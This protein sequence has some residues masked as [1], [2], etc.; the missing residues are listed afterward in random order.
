MI[1]KLHDRGKRLAICVAGGFLLLLL[2][3]QAAPSSSLASPTF[4]EPYDLARGYAYARH[5]DL[6][7]QQEHPVL[8]DGLGGLMLLLMPELTPPE[9]IPGWDDAHLFRFSQALLW[10]L[11]H[12]VDKMVFLARFPVI[13]LALILGA[14]VYRWAAD[15]Y[16]VPGGLLALALYALNPNI[17]A[18]ARILS[19][20]LGAACLAT[21]TLYL[22][23]RWAQ[24][25]TA[26]RVIPAALVLG[27][28][29]AAKTTNMLLI[30][31]IGVLT[32]IRS[33][34][35]RWRWS[36]AVI[37]WGAMASGALFVLWALYRFELGPA[38]NLIGDIPVPAAS[39][40]EAIA[41]VRH[42]MRLG[43][44]AFLWGRHTIWGWWYYFPFAFLVKTP[45]PLLILLVLAVWLHIRR[46]VAQPFPAGCSRPLRSA[47][48]LSAEYALWIF[49]PFYFVLSAFST[50]NL[51]YR[52]ILSTVPLM[53]IYAARVVTWPGM[54]PTL[55]ARNQARRYS[56]SHRGGYGVE[57]RWARRGLWILLTWLVVTAVCIFPHHLA[58]FNELVGGPS[59]GYRYLVDS[60]LDWGQGLKHLRRYLVEH[61]IDDLWL[62]YFGTA[63]PAYY[64]HEAGINYRS[65]FAP[66]STDIAEGFSPINPAPGWYA[67]SATVLQGPFSP[68]PDLFDWFRRHEPIAK[69]GY[70][71]FVYRVEPDPD[72]PAWLGFCYTP[73]AVMSDAEIVHR[74]G[75]DDLRIVHFDCEQTW[76]YS[77]DGSPA[78]YLIPTASSGPGTLAEESL[79]GA[80]IVY[81]ERGLREV[82]GYVVWNV[83]SQRVESALEDIAPGRDVWSSP[84]LA[85]AEADPATALSAPVDIGG[86]VTFLGYRL[87][88]SEPSPG[89]SRFVAARRTTSPSETPFRWRTVPSPEASSQWRTITPLEAPFRW[90]TASSLEAPFRWRTITPVEAPFRWRGDEILVTTAWRVDGRPKDPPFSVF[91]HLVG[92]SGAVSVGDGLGFPAIQ[93]TPG[94]VFV[95]RNRLSIPSEIFPGRYWVQVG[96]YSLTTGERLPVLEGGRPIDD[97]LLLSPIEVE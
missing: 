95:Q 25:P 56:P 37:A 13:G 74:F 92:A 44:P 10:E 43:R 61:D 53:T 71:I 88:S 70:S 64:L 18:H 48:K 4:D 85:P 90:R 42:E 29:L 15:L 89:A 1:H 6:R 81:R 82:P 5:T 45:L 68:E 93:W 66:G 75:R 2:F 30:P 20:D 21:S 97:R 49:P 72:P 23:W 91:A 31:L 87:G 27:L 8:V 94:D 54:S 28:A 12:D 33:V 96:L 40:W 22:W 32:L 26:G 67:I 52:H 16:S 38:P 46:R 34:E 76:V 35:Q 51:G 59:N 65:L 73:E 11:G 63:D 78:W 41:W 86:Q 36:R 47:S 80:E 39:Y 60:N 69:V 57:R 62:G 79:G 83:E 55:D 7:M 14:V 84:V 17:V 58:Y 24:R 19:T 9:Q 50:L 77:T 3:L